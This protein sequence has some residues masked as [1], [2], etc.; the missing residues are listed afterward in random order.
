M[1]AT[2]TSTDTPD[3]R[4]AEAV[5]TR[6][7]ARTAIAVFTAVIAACAVVLTAKVLT[8]DTAPPPRLIDQDSLAKQVTAAINGVKAA[9]VTKLECPT[10]V[11]AQPGLTFECDYNQGFNGGTAIVTVHDDMGALGIEIRG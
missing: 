11:V 1:T 8:L 10:A 6:S 4:P 3:A 9:A 7:S 5:R 2:E